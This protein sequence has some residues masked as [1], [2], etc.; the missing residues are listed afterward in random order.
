MSAFDA[1]RHTVAAFEVERCFFTNG[2]KTLISARRHLAITIAGCAAAA[3]TSWAAAATPLYCVTCTEPDINYTCE[4]RG[5]AEQAANGMQGQMLCIK[6]LAAESGHK[7]CSVNRNAPAPCSGPLR[8]VGPPDSEH[9]A[10]EA[11][12]KPAAKVRPGSIAAVPATEP[13]GTPAKGPLET[14]GQGITDAA[15]KSWSCVTSL[16][17]DC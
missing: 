5:L 10:A 16:F 7:T 12:P 15:K 4:V 6:A 17:K 1:A 13:I 9:N 2:T 14:A 11:N 3:V 8:V